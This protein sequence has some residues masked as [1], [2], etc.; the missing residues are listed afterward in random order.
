MIFA[1]KCGREQL[2][3]LSDWKDGKMRI[4]DLSLGLGSLHIKSNWGFCLGFCF[5]FFV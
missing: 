3:W 2:K 1:Y 4:Q 5:C